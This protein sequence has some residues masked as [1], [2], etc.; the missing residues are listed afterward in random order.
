MIDAKNCNKSNLLV[1]HLNWMAI[2]QEGKAIP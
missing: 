2:N 1:S